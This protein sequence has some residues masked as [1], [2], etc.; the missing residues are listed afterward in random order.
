ME[1][2]VFIKIGQYTSNYLSKLVAIEMETTYLLTDVLKVKNWFYSL[3]DETKTKT[4]LMISNL[5]KLIIF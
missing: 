2:L 4:M 3:I 1:F 5:V